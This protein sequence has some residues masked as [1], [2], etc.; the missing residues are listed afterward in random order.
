MLAENT[1]TKKLQPFIWMRD[2]PSFAFLN[3]K[4]MSSCDGSWVVQRWI[5]KR[6]A[7]IKVVEFGQYLDAK[8]CQ[9]TV[10]RNGVVY[11][12]CLMGSGEPKRVSG[13]ITRFSDVIL[14]FKCLFFSGLVSS[15]VASQ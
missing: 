2:N 6:G 1:F 4:M 5:P 7:D 12:L 11:V 13:T 10:D 15:V 3:D 8:V 9:V 14:Q